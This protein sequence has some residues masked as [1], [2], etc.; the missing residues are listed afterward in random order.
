[1]T[2]SHSFVYGALLKFL[3]T[4]ERLKDPCYLSKELL[5]IHRPQSRL[6]PHTKAV[7]GPESMLHTTKETK[8]IVSEGS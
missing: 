8:V 6:L 5:G 1:M 7:L 3:Y 2:N 4:Y